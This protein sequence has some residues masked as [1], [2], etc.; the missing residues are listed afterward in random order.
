MKT[1]FFLI[2]NIFAT[3]LVAVMAVAVLHI[4]AQM[5]QL[6]M[7]V[8]PPQS[9]DEVVLLPNPTN[10]SEFYEC[11]GG[12]PVRRCCTDGLYYC[13]EKQICTWIWDEECSFDCIT[14]YSSGNCEN[15][16]TLNILG[17]F[18]CSVTCSP[19]MRPSCTLLG[20]CKCVN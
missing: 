1:K 16:C 17:V 19:P 9:G 20:G 11:H 2:T 6:R 4:N 18:K 14:S 12:V 8:C 7:P 10:C 3:V 15:E 5:A 13:P